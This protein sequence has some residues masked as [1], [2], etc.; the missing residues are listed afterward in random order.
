MPSGQ[1]PILH[2]FSLAPGH[3]FRH[4]IQELQSPNLLGDLYCFQG[5]SIFLKLCTRHICDECNAL[6]IKREE[7]HVTF[8]TDSALDGTIYNGAT[9]E[10]ISII[11]LANMIAE[12]MGIAEPVIK[13]EGYRESDPE[14]RL[15]STE[16]IKQRTSWKPI[17]N[18]DKGLTECVEN[19]SKN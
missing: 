13:F 7:N 10:E 15:L 11:D 17:M 5:A 4:L 6:F 3:A 14:R 19:Y 2:A 12:K 8:K 18:L 1:A 16:K 9:D